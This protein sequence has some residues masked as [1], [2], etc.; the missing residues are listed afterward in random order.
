MGSEKREALRRFVRQGARLVG[1]DG[2]ALGA[3]TMLD[4]SADGARLKLKAS[5]ALPEQ[6]V[7]LLSRDGRLRRPCTVAWQ[8]ENTVGVG[9]G[10]KRLI[11]SA[12][13]MPRP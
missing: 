10:P 12:R 6:F 8:L 1:V 2:S 13:F 11:K 4:V 9:F 5:D 7:L 3:C